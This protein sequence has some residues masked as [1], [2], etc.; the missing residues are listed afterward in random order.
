[1]KRIV[2]ILVCFVGLASYA[3]NIPADS[4]DYYRRSAHALL[5]DRRV[6]EA[7]DLYK[8]LALSGDA[9]SGYQL[10]ELYSQGERVQKD[11]VEAEKWRALKISF[12]KPIKNLVP[13]TA[14]VRTTSILLM[15][16]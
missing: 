4:L 16:D 13:N 1:M 10:H 9:L 12:Q 11:P 5:I 2:F 3:Q 7:V 8:R 15:M 14:Q 6:D